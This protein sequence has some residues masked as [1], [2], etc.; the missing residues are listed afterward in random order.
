M[1]ILS[2]ASRS[3]GT[4]DGHICGGMPLAVNRSVKCVTRPAGRF[5]SW[6]P[7]RLGGVTAF[8][9]GTSHDSVVTFSR[10]SGS[11]PDRGGSRMGASA[12]S[13]LGRPDASLSKGRR[14]LSSSAR[15]NGLLTLGGAVMLGRPRL[16]FGPKFDS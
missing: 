11:V 9:Q 10:F 5:A 16:M 6:A 3:I 14:I 2:P 1:F 4:N 15:L 8:G 13:R 7:V 12:A